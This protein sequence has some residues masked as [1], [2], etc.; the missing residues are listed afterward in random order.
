METVSDRRF[1]KQTVQGVILD[2]YWKNEIL[3]VHEKGETG[4]KPPGWALPGGNMLLENHRIT[5]IYDA[6]LVARDGMKQIEHYLSIFEIPELE[7]KS[8]VEGIDEYLGGTKSSK[9]NTLVW[10]TIVREVLEETGI[11]GTPKREL[12]VD[13]V[14]RGVEAHNVIVVNVEIGFEGKLSKRSMETDDC[15]FF[16]MNKL[17]RDIYQTHFSR[18][19]RAVPLIVPD[20]KITLVKEAA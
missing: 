9:E 2:P 11:L 20:R 19:C 16:P 10:L 14:F 12:F 15:R 5:G 8:V 17:P 18:I 13:E 4:G 1:L 6:E 3:L 7:W